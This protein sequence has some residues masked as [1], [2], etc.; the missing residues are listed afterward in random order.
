M[1]GTSFSWLDYSEHERQ[2]MLDAINL[3]QEK[4]T[5]DELGLG[6][7]RDTFADMLFPGTSTIQTRARYFLFI[8][9]IYTLLESRQVDSDRM[10]FERKKMEVS[11]I[12]ELLKTDDQ[13]G[14]IG[15]DAREDL[16]RFP[17]S[18]YWLGLGK[19]GLRIFDGSQYQYQKSVDLFYQSLSYYKDSVRLQSVSDCS[20]RK[21][22]DTFWQSQEL[23]C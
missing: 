20:A 10:D 23:C 7:I 2:K 9:W 19:W 11:L 1:V 12:Y 22:R 6:T 18:I 17:S 13:D 21:L 3:F 15:T 14:L 5:R 16:Q 8:P 4:D